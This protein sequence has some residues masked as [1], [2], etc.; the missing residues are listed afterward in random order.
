MRTDALPRVLNRC[1]WIF[2]IAAF[3]RV[4]ESA[5]REAWVQRYSNAVSNSVDQAFK[6]LT[7]QA[8]DIIVAGTSDNGTTG[9]DILTIKYSGADGSTLWQRRYDGPN[10][11]DD[12]IS[13]IGLDRDGNVVV[14]GIS[15]PVGEWGPGEGEYYTAKYGAADGA[16]LWEVRRPKGFF[17]YNNNLPAQLAVDGR[18]DVVVSMPGLVHPDGTGAYISKFAGGSGALLW[19][20]RYD[21]EGYDWLNSLA[22]DAN[23]NVFAGGRSDIV[24]SLP[25]YHVVKYSAEG[26][27]VWEKSSSQS[28]P[29]DPYA[30]KPI[31]VDS[32]GNLI[33]VSYVGNEDY[34]IQSRKY[35][36]T[37][38]VTLWTNNFLTNWNNGSMVVA[39]ASNGDVV[40]MGSAYL[41]K[42]AAADGSPVWRKMA[43]A[44]LGGHIPTSVTVDGSD[45][46][47]VAGLYSGD[48]YVAK[49][50]AA[51]GSL[52]WEKKYNSPGAS[53][54]S[55][56]A[57]AVAVDAEGNV[58][59]TGASYNALDTAKYSGGDAALIWEQLH[60]GV[61]NRND[62]AT[63]VALDAAGNVIVTG[64]S[65]IENGARKSYTAK[66]ATANGLLLW[67]R[68]TLAGW[69]QSSA[70]VVVDE[71][72]DVAISSSGHTAKY[73]SANGA[74]LWEKD[75]TFTSMEVA[76]DS[77][78]NVLV[79]GFVRTDNR[80]DYYTVKYAAADGTILWEKF[81]STA[82]EDV[83]VG[84]AIDSKGDVLVTGI[85]NFQFYTVKYAGLDGM[86]LWEKRHGRTNSLDAIRAIAVDRD[87]NVVITGKLF[88][89]YLAGG[90]QAYDYYTAKYAA[91]TGAL[92]WEKSYDGPLKGNDEARAVAIDLN[93]NVVVS[94]YSQ[95]DLY[96]VKYS[97]AAGAMLWET[98]TPSVNPSAMGLDASNN[99][100]VVGS[101][102]NNAGA[103][104]YYTA[105]FA[106]VDGTTL[107]EQ[108]YNGPANSSDFA[109][110][111]AIGRDGR[112]AVTGSSNSNF[113]SCC[114]EAFDFATIVYREGLSA[115]LIQYIFGRVHLSFTGTVGQTYYIQRAPSV[116]GPWTTVNVNAAL[117]SG[118]I[119]YDGGAATEEASFY[120]VSQL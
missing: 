79:T 100:V 61:A 38:G 6:V 116:E 114:N 64:V 65:E 34:K 44:G 115:V 45:N 91:N 85:S 88:V 81:Y 75:F 101:A 42:H 69:D 4:A 11:L 93:G 2:L 22:V 89:K 49:Y 16:T 26:E 32:G 12:R 31:A 119:E 77:S 58:V 27:V 70:K 62:D 71:S 120:R 35:S 19:Q 5:V 40:I 23:G 107:W 30:P 53:D 99:F 86:L 17:S 9:K 109:S 55:D 39:I 25:L 20:K 92:L 118:L 76:L 21:S 82:G 1:A 84:L 80:S 46:V 54:D 14:V 108:R 57:V 113:S 67:S 60:R 117:V 29:S 10:K 110:S 50:A 94:G 73:A 37:D 111:L 56:S 74:S 24:D 104:D 90:E 78:G 95:E 41:G 83:P 72:G 66:Y 98:R 33:V 48:S 96:I 36:G 51:D 8:G 102:W 18:G 13:G 52:I 103:P 105:K 43:T 7:D 47:V 59:V 28:D 3:C 63:D 97:A 106:S 87:G 15:A 112:V 68:E